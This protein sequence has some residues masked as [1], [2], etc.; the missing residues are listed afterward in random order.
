[1]AL[2]QEVLQRVA[3]EELVRQAIVQ[4]ST[5]KI[6]LDVLRAALRQSNVNNHGP[7]RFDSSAVV[8]DAGRL[9][10]LPTPWPTLN[11]QIEG[12]LYPKELGMVM[13]TPKVGK[14]TV[15]LNLAAEALDQGWYL[16][17]VTAADQGYSDI[18]RRMAGVWL[19]TSA[20]RLRG[21]AQA[22]DSALGGWTARGGVFAVADYAA[23][24]C[25]M[26]DVERDIEVSL[27]EAEG[28][29]VA[30]IID[31]LERVP[32]AGS[33]TEARWGIL[34]SFEEA[35]MLA[36]KCAVP[37]WCDSQASL[38]QQRRDG[39]S[40]D[41]GWVS[42]TRGAEARV[43]KAMTVDLFLGIGTHPEDEN[44]LRVN[45]QGRREILE[46]R[47]ELHRNPHSGVVRQ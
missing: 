6:D 26:S 5:G 36:H 8:G 35:R 15:L 17:Y 19:D 39:T 23:R 30:V 22:L 14:T 24:P 13:A 20:S 10:P 44:V 43:G 16:L 12:G 41:D 2:A 25:H 31:R 4:Q 27:E 3:L 9:Q 34:A 42:I 1:M 46:H 28:R 32:I 45:I 38:P 40:A 47:F 7:R 33:N 37:I 11:A 18:S 21:D 29:R